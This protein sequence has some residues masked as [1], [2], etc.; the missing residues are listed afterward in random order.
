MKVIPDE[1]IWFFQHQ[2]MV[3]VSTIGKDGLPHNSCKGLVHITNNGYVYLLDLYK[4][5][6]FDN[7]KRNLNISITGVNEHKFVGYCLKGKAKISKQDK[8]SP[9]LIKAWDKKIASRLTKR[10][11]KEIHGEKGHKQHPEALLPNP[12]YLIV[13]KIK[14]IVDLTP[15]HLK[16]KGE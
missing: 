14:E 7:L 9:R 5:K 15:H 1:V 10:L 8:L 2:H 13:V 11:L 12:E 3:I 6:T 16:R 4:R